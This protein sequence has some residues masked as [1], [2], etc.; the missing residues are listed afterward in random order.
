MQA[1]GYGMSKGSFIAR[2]TGILA[3]LIVLMAVIVKLEPKEPG[4]SKARAAKAWALCMASA[5]EIS[6]YR[7]AGERNYFS[8]KEQ[9]NW[10]VPYM[11]YLYGVG[12]LLPE[13]TE[14]SSQK[15]QQE[16]T[17]REVQ[18]LASVFGDE[19]RQMVHVT[20]R[21]KNKAYPEKLWWQLY[22]SLVQKVG[23]VVPV[24]AI[25]YGTPQNVPQAP[26][27]TCYTNE[28]DFHFEGLAL[29]KYIDQK[30]L[31]YVRDKEVAG[32]HQ[33]VQQDVTYENVW[34]EDIVQ[35]QIRIHAGTITR[36]FAVPE[37]VE[38]K[39]GLRHNIVDLHLKKGQIEKIAIKNERIAGKVLAVG[40]NEIEIEGYGILPLAPGFRVYKVYGEYQ[41]QKKSDILVGYQLQEF[42][43]AGGKLCA[44]LT[45]REFDGEKI[46]V[47]LMNNGFSE[48]THPLVTFTLNSEA[49]LSWGQEGQEEQLE[50][51]QQI[52]IA[53]D[54]ER[55]AGGHI[56]IVP[57]GEKGGIRIDSI[58]RSQG[59]P[60]YD[61][62]LEIRADEGGL[63]LVNEV[64]LEDYLKK[65]VPSEMPA[66]YELE[67]LKA[68]AVCART[69]A[70]RHIQG[71]SYSK[72]G[73]HVDDSTNFQVYNNIKAEPKSNQAV[74]ETYGEILFYEGA[75]VE[76]F[77][78]STS[79]GHGSD[80]TVW[81]SEADSIPYLA[82]AE[83]RERKSTL[84][85]TSEPAFGEFI[86]NNEI[87]AY[88]SSSPMYR[89]KALYKGTTL[90]KNLGMGIVE[91]LNI[92]QRGPGGV[93]KVLE[94]T[95]ADGQ[96]KIIENQMN[97]RKAL[98]SVDLEIERK[99]GK[100]ITDWGLLPSA[101]IYI[102]EVG[103]AKDESKLFQIYGGGYGHGVG[104]SQNGAQGMA[105]EGKTYTD[106]LEFFYQGTQLHK[107]NHDAQ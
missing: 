104:M 77:Y 13:Y 41:E 49:V 19:Y 16:I 91:S 26:S 107:L 80:E 78:Y 56:A 5:E 101:F 68:Q 28:G 44:A 35:G 67:A 8:E 89:W 72:Y 53:P 1:R 75:P 82:A 22:G 14:A 17:Y 93:A 83:L 32:I 31:I 61:G 46:R 37:A 12:A 99:D 42:V 64:F 15:A 43:A 79:S 9:N 40:E 51:G 71:N 92:T 98:G 65:V 34:V 18:Q 33:V 76:A 10:Y 52:T 87:P 23:G 21:N 69:Y 25:I 66:Y 24:E 55:L 57:A 100:T 30:I 4:I 11:N 70:Y 6:Q 39:E 106:I 90:G 62:F 27:W 94:I 102:E 45:V 88:D 59:K 97:I 85:L 81:G 95:D 29:D 2:I 47:L 84:D 60:V 63:V 103:R 96:T 105:R 73:A 48:I 86:K 20:S 74:M 38:D 3:L 50:K 54:D 36:E 58:E 7:G